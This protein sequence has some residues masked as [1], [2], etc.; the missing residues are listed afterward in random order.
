MKRILALALALMLLLSAS[1]ALAE[2]N[3]LQWPLVSEGESKTITVAITRNWSKARIPAE[4]SWF[5]HYLTEKSGLTFELQTI[6]TN[7]VGQR[8]NLMFVSGELP[9]LMLGLGFTT[10][11]LVKYGQTEHQLLALE[12]YIT[13][14]IMPNLY[15]WVNYNSLGK[16]LCTAPDGHMYTLPAY[17]AEANA[18]GSTQN[19]FIRES[20][21]N[22]LNLKNPDTLDELIDVVYKLKEAY[23]DSY[24]IS[25]APTNTGVFA[26]ILRAMGILT[27]GCVS[28]A[29]LKGDQVTIPCYDDIYGEYLKLIHQ[30]YVDGIVSPDLYTT[31]EI[32][33]KSII[34]EGNSFIINN[35][36]Y[37]IDAT[38]EF[39][40]QWS[41]VKALTSQWNDEPMWVASNTINLGGVAVSAKTEHAETIM[42]LLDFFWSD[43]GGL[44]VWE[45]P[46][47]G[48]EDTLGMV[49]GWEYNPET[50]KKTFLDAQNNPLYEKNNQYYVVSHM[51]GWSTSLGNRCRTLSHLGQEDDALYLTLEETMQEMAGITPTGRKWQLDNGDQFSRK[52][53]HELLTDCQKQGFPAFVYYDEDTTIAISDLSTVISNYA[54]TEVAKFVTGVRNV[55][56]FPQFQKELQSMGVDEL[57]GYY[58]EGYAAYKAAL[59][60]E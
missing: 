60:Q 52:S 26:W 34:A 45:G 3:Q 22:E 39:F 15:A 28:N 7:A 4:D 36:P 14:D 30:F 24:P 42:R 58:A 46:M 29:A 55:E 47:A 54:A 27:D 48:T 57:I 6:D 9:D 1:T 11:E 13:E 21:L 40:Q 20:V 41:S 37:M 43:F 25:Y 10:N 56:E 38:P 19:V 2:Y 32:T 16:V 5:W 51:G 53:K 31:D 18:V 33:N 49:E 50:M 23:P 44:S 17:R 59:A 12:D 8:K 35:A